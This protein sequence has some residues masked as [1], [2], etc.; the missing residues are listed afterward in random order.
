MG[1]GPQYRWRG[2]S[3]ELTDGVCHFIA[4]AIMRYFAALV[5]FLVGLLVTAA[6]LI[7]PAVMIFG[8]NAPKVVIYLIVGASLGVGYSAGEWAKRRFAPKKVGM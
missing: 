7:I 1:H 3:N 5:A 2:F 8:D 6:V 4:G